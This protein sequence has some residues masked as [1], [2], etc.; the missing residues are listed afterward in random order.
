[1]NA[2]LL[3]R[4]RVVLGPNRFA[5]LVIWQVPVPLA[6][7]AHPFKYRL[8]FV[9]DELCVLRYD[10]EPGKG[11]HKHLGRDESPYVFTTPDQL[12]DDFWAD[13]ARL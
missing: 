13:V 3:L 6:G 1:M 12:V 4:S 10:N 11:D 7:S 5:D 8:A 2:V 9:V